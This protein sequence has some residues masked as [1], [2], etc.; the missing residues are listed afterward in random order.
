MYTQ[1]HLEIPC[2]DMSDAVLIQQA[3]DGDRSAFEDLV[4]RYTTP[5]FNFICRLMGDYDLASDILQ[6]VV[7]QL[8]I[9]LASLNRAKPVKAWLFQVAHN[10]CVDEFRHK[11]VVYFSQLEWDDDGDEL[12]PL[13]AIPD[14]NPLPEEL[15]ERHDLQEQLNRAIRMLPAR[16]RDIVLLRYVAQLSFAEI[17]R[18]LHIPEST[19]KTYFQRAKPLLRTS[20]SELS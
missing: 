4:R 9:S 20:L 19:A 15:A 5:L 10:R 1:K 8:Y 13:T 16:Y 18:T 14:N 12:S 7:L 11:K 17:G 3:L 2:K 6:Q